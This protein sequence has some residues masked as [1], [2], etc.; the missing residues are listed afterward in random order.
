MGRRSGSRV[1]RFVPLESRVNPNGCPRECPDHG[2]CPGILD[3]VDAKNSNQTTRADFLETRFRK[4]FVPAFE[5]WRN[6]PGFSGAG[7]IPPGTPFSFSQYQPDSRV[8]ATRL[9][10]EATAT[11]DQGRVANAIGDSY[12]L[13]TVLFAI[14]LFLAGFGTK[15]RSKKL[16]YLFLLT[17][18]GVSAYAIGFLLTLPRI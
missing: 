14:V 1:R 11:F 5:A 13:N 18:I 7:E 2:R 8:N 9:A 4:E 10:D 12:I 3:W 6:Q 17:G 15:W 16:Q